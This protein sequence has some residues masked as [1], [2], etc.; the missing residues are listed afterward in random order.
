MFTYHESDDN[1]DKF[2]DCMAK[3]AT[4]VNSIDSTCITIT[5]DFNADI[6]IN[7]IF[8]SILYNFFDEY[9]LEICDKDLL[10]ADTHFCES[11]MGHNLVARSHTVHCRCQAGDQCYV[12]LL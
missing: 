9:S 11:C 4:Y 12:C 5:G 8:G 1:L 3:I 7:S 2:I 10:P 6:S